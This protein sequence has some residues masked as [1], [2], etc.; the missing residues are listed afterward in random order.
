MTAGQLEKCPACSGRGY[1]HCD[2]WP[3][4]CICG[5][6][7]EDCEECRG[8]GWIDPAYDDDP[9]LDELPEGEK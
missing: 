1:H 5:W 4:D 8:N 2:C 6:G 3:G 7:D 9:Y